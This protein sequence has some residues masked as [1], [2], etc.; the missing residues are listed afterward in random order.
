MLKQAA[1]KTSERA[2]YSWDNSYKNP[3][4]GAFAEGENDGLYWRLTQD[5]MLS[6]LF[7]WAGAAKSTEVSIPGGSGGS[8]PEKKLSAAASWVPGEMSGNIKYDNGMLLRSIDTDLARPISFPPLERALHR[9]LHPEVSA[10]SGVTDPVEYI[11]N[12][13]LMRY[14]A[15][16]AAGVAG[17]ILKLDK[18]GAILQ[19]FGS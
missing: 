3:S 18:A 1:S 7:G 9:P 12:I 11:R 2:A 15:A 13:E 6:K 14:Y 10:G 8:L 5:D 4:N 16:K 17:P 19:W